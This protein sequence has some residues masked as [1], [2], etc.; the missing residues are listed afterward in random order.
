MNLKSALNSGARM[1]VQKGPQAQPRIQG[2]QPAKAQP[3]TSKL[4]KTEQR[5]ADILEGR[6]RMGLLQE[7]FV[8]AVALKLGDRSTYWPDFLIVHNDGSLEFLEIKG[9]MKAVGAAKFKI[10]RTMFWWAKF[11]M[12]SYDSRRGWY[13]NEHASRDKRPGE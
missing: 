13:E 5:Y 1:R 3:R 9:F 12:M 8:Q 7:Y 2:P 10:A 11:T 6:K 4:N